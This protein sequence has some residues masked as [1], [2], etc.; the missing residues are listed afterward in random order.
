MLS[1]YLLNKKIASKNK[2]SKQRP[3]GRWLLLRVIK[4]IILIIYHLLTITI[5]KLLIQRKK[6]KRK[7]VIKDREED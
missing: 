7:N 5:F 6:K 4:I 2:R 3:F 1:I